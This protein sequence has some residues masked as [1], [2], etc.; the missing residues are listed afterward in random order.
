MAS[1]PGNQHP[2]TRLS[3][4]D[5]RLPPSRCHHFRDHWQVLRPP[6]GNHQ[7]IDAERLHSLQVVPQACRIRENQLSRQFL[8]ARRVRVPSAELLQVEIAAEIRH[9]PLA[10]LFRLHVTERRRDFKA[11][12]LCGLF[13]LLRRAKQGGVAR[14]EMNAVRRV[15]G[16]IEPIAAH[17]RDG[18]RD[19]LLDRLHALRDISECERRSF[20]ADRLAR[21]K[22]VDDCDCLR[23]GLIRSIGINARDVGPRSPANREINS[24]LG[25]LIKRR[26]PVRDDGGIPMIRRHD[27]DADPRR[28]CVH[29]RQSR[30][31]PDLPLRECRVRNPYPLKAV[32]IVVLDVLHQFGNGSSDGKLNTDAHMREPHFLEISD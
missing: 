17:G 31:C 32:R 22:P 14:V 20:H 28:R 4:T 26:S 18:Y 23:H 11:G 25:E 29:R 24:S 30:R 1:S 12:I 6:V 3:Q 19:V 13:R 9:P 15:A 16:N 8:I 2:S 27:S 7:L 10:H 5:F 21:E